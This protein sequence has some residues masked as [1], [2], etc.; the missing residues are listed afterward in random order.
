M[1]R[2]ATAQELGR[3]VRDARI[4]IGMT[5]QQLAE[6]VGASLRW[7]TK[8]ETDAST[9]HTDKVIAAVH[10]VGL[11]IDVVGSE[12]DPRRAGIFGRAFDG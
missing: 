5:Q 8:F 11:V 12:P 10:A 2:I 3:T 7:V 1:V 9:S 6:R 4:A